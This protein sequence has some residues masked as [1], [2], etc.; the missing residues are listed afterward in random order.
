MQTLVVFEEVVC[1]TLCKE[2][3]AATAGEGKKEEGTRRPPCGPPSSATPLGRTEEEDEKETKPDGSEASPTNAA[4][5]AMA[6]A[7]TTTSSSS[8]FLPRHPIGVRTFVQMTLFC[9]HSANALVTEMWVAFQRSAPIDEMYYNVWEVLMD[10]KGV[11]SLPTTAPYPPLDPAAL[12]FSERVDVAALGKKICPPLDGEDLHQ[13]K[14]GSHHKEEEAAEDEGKKRTVEGVKARLSR[15]W[16][17]EEEE[18]EEKGFVR[19]EKEE[20]FVEVLEKQITPYMQ[21]IHRVVDERIKCGA[22]LP[23]S[24]LMN[25]LRGD[26]QVQ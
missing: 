16:K 25:C 5:P 11:L 7:A 22:T 13:P 9:L 12:P 26:A 17:D 23:L 10:W 8:S 19:R 24:A 6:A 14:K 18:E 1:Q 20:A 4:I 15:M 3:M 2:A 21:M